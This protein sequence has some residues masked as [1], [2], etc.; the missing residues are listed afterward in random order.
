MTNIKINF[1]GQTIRLIKL[2]ETIKTIEEY[3]KNLYTDY[4]K[5]INFKAQYAMRMFN[6]QENGSSVLDK[7]F[8]K[9][10]LYTVP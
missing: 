7:L 4:E 10:L 5:R 9:E 8:H 1:K 6:Y 3:L 2:G